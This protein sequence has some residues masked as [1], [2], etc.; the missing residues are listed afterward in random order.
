MDPKPLKCQPYEEREV[1]PIFGDVTGSKAASVFNSQHERFKKGTYVNPNENPG[2]TDYV[3]A[4]N[5]PSYIIKGPTESKFGSN[6]TRNNLIHRDVSKSPFK[7][8]TCLD[9]PSPAQYAP[10]THELSKGLISPSG[11][12]S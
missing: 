2:P 1:L 7:N 4:T 5:T 3:N 10:K 11:K 12:T 9:N 6:V 8:P